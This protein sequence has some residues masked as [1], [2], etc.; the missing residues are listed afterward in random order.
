MRSFVIRMAAVVLA[1]AAGAPLM[2]ADDEEKVALD[3]VPKAVLDAVKARFPDAEL[4][5]ASKETEDG[6]TSYEIEVKTKKGD[7]AV[8]LTPD[9]DITEI[10]K[11]IEAK[12]LPKA[13]AKTL[14]ENYPKA[15]LGEIEEVTKVEKKEEKL[16]HYEIE[17]KT[18][19]KKV[20]VKID[21]D[22]KVIKHKKE[23]KKDK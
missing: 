22:G 19:D 7:F 20:E 4:K 8:E 9:G 18:G 15:E 13:V 23:E 2:R 11:D 6:K 5:E 21:P 12:D 14:E 16:S 3:K 10:E 1:A 17:I